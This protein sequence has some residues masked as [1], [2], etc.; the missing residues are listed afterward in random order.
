MNQG[1]CHQ[2]LNPDCA[3]CRSL[4]TNFLALLKH[5]KSEVA[6]RY[7]LQ[8]AFAICLTMMNIQ[9]LIN[10]DREGFVTLILLV[11]SFGGGILLFFHAT[12]GGVW[13]VRRYEIAIRFISSLI[14][15]SQQ[16][17]AGS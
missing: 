12:L 7:L 5:T 17:S 16:S 13:E 11:C 1:N 15:E 2:E 6:M 3:Q 4:A 10:I 9:S 8:I 14:K